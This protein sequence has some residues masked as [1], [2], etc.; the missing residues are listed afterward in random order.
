M[1]TFKKLIDDLSEE[2][3]VSPRREEIIA[4]VS[5]E[6]IENH[7]PGYISSRVHDGFAD[8]YFWIEV[9][10]SKDMVPA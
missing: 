3:T 10:L 6:L 1:T 9:S 2:D 8:G 5:R 4:A 7:G